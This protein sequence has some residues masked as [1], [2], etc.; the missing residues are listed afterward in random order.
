M[1]DDDDLIGASEFI[2]GEFKFQS[3]FCV[4]NFDS[5]LDGCVNWD[6][7]PAFSFVL[8]IVLFIN[9]ISRRSNLCMFILYPICLNNGFEKCFIET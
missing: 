2:K 6:L 9:F 3:I 5:L 8:F 4:D 7:T 1:A